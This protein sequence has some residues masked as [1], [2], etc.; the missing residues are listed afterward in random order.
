MEIKNKRFEEDAERA[1]LD[2]NNRWF[3]L[4]P[5]YAEL[6]PVVDVEQARCQHEFEDCPR[7]GH[8]NFWHIKQP[9]SRLRRKLRRFRRQQQRIRYIKKFHFFFFFHF[10]FYILW[11]H[12]DRRD[13][14]LARGRDR[15]RGSANSMSSDCVIALDLGRNRQ[16]GVAGQ[17]MSHRRGDRAAVEETAHRVGKNIENIKA[18]SKR[19]VKML[20]VCFLI[21]FNNQPFIVYFLFFYFLLKYTFRIFRI[22]ILF[23]FV[24]INYFKKLKNNGR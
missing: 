24:L 12:K 22:F 21:D 1:V 20:F 15:C 19:D 7:N 14:S 5:I 2:L 10:S 11:L 18:V 23:L 13:E 6:S 4:K 16:V 8:C 3:N 9:S 17:S